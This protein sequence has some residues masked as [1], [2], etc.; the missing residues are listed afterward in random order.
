MRQVIISVLGILIIGGGFLGMKKMASKEKPEPE[1]VQK[2]TPVVFS[3]I[4]K[5]QDLPITISASG[6]LEA[7]DRVEIYSEVQGIFEY[8]AKSYKPG[9]VYSEGSVLIQL[10][11]DEHKSNLRS[12][13][14][15]LYNQIV[16]LLPDLKFD[17]PQSYEQWQNYITEKDAYRNYLK[18][19]QKMKSYL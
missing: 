3:E 13:K 6:N 16:G 9:V 10:N 12:Q 11:S 15:S 8:S 19:Y 7:R 17:Y 5:N 1:K 2:A 14:S 4:V 18:L